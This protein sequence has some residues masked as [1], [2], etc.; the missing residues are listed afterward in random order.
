MALADFLSAFRSLILDKGPLAD[1]VDARRAELAGR[2]PRLGPREINDLAEI[3]P[4]RIKVYTDLIFAGERATLQWV[5]PR[6][7]AI[8]SDLLHQRDSSKA[9]SLHLFHLV[10]ALHESQPWESPSQ[11][12]LASNFQNFIVQTRRDLL[13]A[14]PPLADLMTYER[15]ELDIFYAED[16]PHL[17]FLPAD[18]ESL[19]NMTVEQ[20]MG[21]E[22]FRPP[23]AAVLHFDYDILNLVAHWD[24]VSAP[25]PSIAIDQPCNAACGRD[26]NSL[27]PHWTR[28]GRGGHAALFQAPANKSFTVEDLAVF[29]IEAEADPRSEAEQFADFFSQLIGWLRAGILMRPPV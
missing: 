23:Y 6:S 24:D 26:I 17:P 21:I 15:T 1:S 13:T 7:S 2:F 29:Y 10:R 19:T 11:R 28:L 8:I 20:L 9:R 27:M 22:L 25:P 18:F 12:Q 3:E 16:I 4:G 14:W 5:Y